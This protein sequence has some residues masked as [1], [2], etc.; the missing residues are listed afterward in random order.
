MAKKTY[1]ILFPRAD[2]VSAE[3]L[4]SGHA[5]DGKFPIEKLGIQAIPGTKFYLNSSRKP[6]IIGST[7]IYELDLPSKVSID[8][9][10][11]D[12]NSVDI[13]KNGSEEAGLGLLIDMVYTEG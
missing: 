11:F 8:A 12:K 2:S 10:R 1:Q 13:I 4:I 7:G 3:E 6:V 5:F 9:L